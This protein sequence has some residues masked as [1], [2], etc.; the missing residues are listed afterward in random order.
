MPELLAGQI[1]DK[2]TLGI[3]HTRLAFTMHAEYFGARRDQPLS[4]EAAE[5]IDCR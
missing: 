1:R 3:P 4:N 5:L 2:W